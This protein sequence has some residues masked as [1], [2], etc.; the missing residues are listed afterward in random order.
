MTADNKKIT[1]VYSIT[2]IENGLKYIGA[3][4]DINRR[5]WQHINSLRKN[6]H[7]SIYLQDDYNLYGEKSFRFDIIEK[8]SDNDILTEREQFWYD[9]YKPHKREN[10]YN[11]NPN[12]KDWTG[13][14]HFQQTIDKIKKAKENISE[15]TRRKISAAAMGRVSA[16]K[17]HKHTDETKAIFRMKK[18]GTKHTDDVRKKMSIDRKGLNRGSKN[19]QSKYSDDVIIKA[20]EMSFQGQT[21]NQVSYFYGI[22]YR[23]Y[24][25]I[26]RGL[27]RTYIYNEYTLPR[28]INGDILT[29]D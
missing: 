12:A 7:R 20:I 26:L 24:R 22:D 3:T 19:G 8:V 13:R 23:Y 14:K 10:G 29:I 4:I 1:G 11:V 27:K 28:I 6:R 17:G 18:L 2:N 16:F 25:S 21:A 5:W 15:E 9:Y